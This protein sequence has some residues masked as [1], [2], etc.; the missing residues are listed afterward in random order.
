[1]QTAL[2]DLCAAGETS[3]ALF[4]VSLCVRN[5]VR[6]ARARA[7]SEVLSTQLSS[8][9]DLCAAAFAAPALT[10]QKT[11]PLRLCDARSAARWRLAAGL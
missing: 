11:A 7:L 1:M 9:A 4:Q 6:V 2:A 3:G 8:R 10:H 5:L